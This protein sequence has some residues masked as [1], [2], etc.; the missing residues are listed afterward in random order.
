MYGDHIGNSK[1]VVP[2]KCHTTRKENRLINFI[3]IDFMATFCSEG[4][5]RQAVSMKNR[6]I[7]YNF[8]FRTA[9]LDIITVLFIH[10]LM[11]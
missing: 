1:I 6:N 9:H 4:P 2:V 3:H 8:H 11:H 5:V 10:Q 7:N